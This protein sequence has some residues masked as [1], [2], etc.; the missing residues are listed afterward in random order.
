MVER[1]GG[2]GWRRTGS[3]STTHRRTCWSRPDPALD[4]ALAANAAA[5][6]PAIDVSPLQGKL[7]HI[8]A[9][10]PAPAAS[11]RSARSAATPRSGSP[12]RCPRR[13]ARHARGRP[14]PRRGGARQHRRAPGWPTGSRSDVGPALDT[15]PGARRAVRLRLH[16]RR[17]AQ[18][19]R[20]PA[21]GAPAVAAGHRHRLRQRGARGRGRRR[22]QQRPGRRRHARAF[23]TC[24]R[25]EPRLTATAVQTVGAK[26]WDGFAIA[27]V[28]G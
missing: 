17:Q 11:S 24:S 1:E 20:L 19:P 13:P 21:L 27:I 15:L 3:A 10:M 7:L 4:A 5:G 25:A 28:A 8:L 22:G 18:Q 9:R 6:L 23:S 16:R 2:Q 14:P 12:A 26:G